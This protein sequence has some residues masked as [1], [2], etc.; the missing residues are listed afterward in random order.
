MSQECRYR[1]PPDF[2]VSKLGKPV[3]RLE[4]KFEAEQKAAVLALSFLA[5]ARKQTRTPV[6]SLKVIRP[7]P[8]CSSSLTRDNYVVTLARD[9]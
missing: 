9:S 3:R 5:E 6:R 1:L 4:G 2:G 8:L 7:S